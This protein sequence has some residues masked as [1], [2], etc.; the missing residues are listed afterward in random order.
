MKA[1]L[2][3][4]SH[5]HGSLLQSLLR[6]LCRQDGIEHFHVV[7][8]L[9]LVSEQLDLAAYPQLQM[10]VVR[11]SVPKGFGA[12]HNAAFRHCSTPWFVVVN[13]DIRLP[14]AT[15]M[16]RLLLLDGP[17]DGAGLRAPVVTN[18]AGQAEDSV[19]AHLTPLS[20]LKRV[21][22]RDQELLK[23]LRPASK[24][25]PFYW[26]AGMFMAVRSEAFRRVGGFDE[27]F[28]LYCEDYDLCARL[29]LSGYAIVLDQQVSVVHDAQRDSHHSVQH[30]R[31][32]LGSLMRVWLSPAFWR[33]LLA[34]AK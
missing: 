11:N 27:R 1:T 29:Y 19:R 25:G 8:T 32:H 20:L 13:P 12:N 5:G 26:L 10:T 24:G 6:D 23:P 18:S 7:V 16:T 15:A 30:L 21:S 22:G 2:S 9:N 34:R 14:D 28:F 31:W 4:V 17:A 33:V 3:V